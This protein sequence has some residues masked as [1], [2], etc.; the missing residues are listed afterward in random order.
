[1]T[2]GPTLTVA[3]APA[4]P[5]ADEPPG[6]W[7][8]LSVLAVAM[9]LSMAPWFS[10]AAVLP[11]LRRQ[12]DLSASASAWL[13]IA[14]QVG[15]VVGALVSATFNLADTLRPKHL[16][17]IGALGAG[18]ANLA[19]LAASGASTAIPM[20][21]LTGIFLA[22]V[23]PPAMKA[24]ATWFRVGRGTALG[25]MVGALTLGSALPHLVNGLGG[26][27]WRPLIIAT[28][29]LT[30]SG[31]LLAEL[32][33]TDGPFAFPPGSFDP[34]QIGHLVR[35]RRMRLATLGYFGHM[36][37]LYAMWAWF[38][39]FYTDVVA[40]NHSGDQSQR[41]AITTFVVIGVGALG[42]WTGG[43]I[44][45]RWGR[46]NAAA[47]AMAISG[48]AAVVIGL[49]RNGPPALVVAVAMIWGFTVVAD[50][51]QFSAIVTEVADQRYVGTAVTLQL[52]A[53]FILTVATIWLVPI[54]RDATGWSW[55]FLL[56]AP[57]PLLGVVAMIRLRPLLDTPPTP[58]Q[59]P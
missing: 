53:G 46:A 16:M 25:I 2:S 19:L 4:R 5:S 3:D 59:T 28:S 31:G 15:F 14:V 22:G 27:Q 39:V 47:L 45:D 58:G 30:I 41:V 10:A 37:E 20:R 54:V 9:V 43:M 1:M 44:S 18:A 35:D 7:R 17:L 24:V 13:T 34:S 32:R 57:G 38:A 51:A 6:R 40:S 48:T 50:S 12:W 21:F 23:Y 42:S 36:W 11:Q 29:L 52:A 33:F 55:A 8:A 49:V 56:L 26:A